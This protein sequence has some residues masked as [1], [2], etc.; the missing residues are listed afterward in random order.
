MTDVDSLIQQIKIQA[1]LLSKRG[2]DPLLEPP[3]LSDDEQLYLYR[4]VVDMP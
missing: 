3:P 1:V 4:R 2:L